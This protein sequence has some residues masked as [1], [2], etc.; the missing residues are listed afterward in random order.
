MATSADHQRAVVA[1]DLSISYIEHGSNRKH[2]AVSGISFELEPGEILGVVGTAGSGKSALG[3]ILSGRR[4][5]GKG[6]G[7]S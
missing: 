4:R 1:D 3:R 7:R 5:P 6:S 2:E